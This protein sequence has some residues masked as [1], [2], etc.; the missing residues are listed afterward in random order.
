MSRYTDAKLDEIIEMAGWGDTSLLLLALSFIKHN[1]EADKFESYCRAQA[2]A[3]L[4][5]EEI[6]EDKADEVLRNAARSG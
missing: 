2:E 6:E 5:E 3:E 4:S 1:K